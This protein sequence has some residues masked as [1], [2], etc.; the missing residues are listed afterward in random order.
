MVTEQ[1][2][3][4]WVIGNGGSQANASHLV[5]H[6]QEH[7][8]RAHDLLAETA[9]ITA[10]S[11]DHDYVKVAVKT[12]RDLGSPADILIAISC[13]GDS[14]NVILGLVEA[15]RIGMK[16]YGLLGFAGGQA[17]G[18][19]TSHVLIPTTDYG[20]IEDCHSSL[21]H[22]INRYLGIKNSS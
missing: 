7:S 18:L 14:P 6:L 13:S 5:L 4:A 9:R 8:I 17:I 2:G 19:C 20:H 22:A 12:L 15:R 11:N 1:R 21:I 10:L 16:T 3:C